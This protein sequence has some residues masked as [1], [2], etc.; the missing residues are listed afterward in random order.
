LLIIDGRRSAGTAPVFRLSGTNSL[1]APPKN[2][3]A[4]TWA[5]IRLSLFR[6]RNPGA[7]ADALQGRIAANTEA[8]RGFPAVSS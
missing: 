8:G 2:R 6:L 1:G 5:L 3:Q 7:E 4:L